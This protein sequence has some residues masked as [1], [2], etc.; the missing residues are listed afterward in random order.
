[1]VEVDEVDEEELQNGGGEMD[2]ESFSM[3]DMGEVYSVASQFQN[4]ATAPSSK[5][6]YDQTV[7]DHNFD[8]ADDYE[9]DFEVKTETCV[10]PG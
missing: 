3:R 10:K 8:E 7:E 1:M 9:E 6:L 4:G 5:L 2:D